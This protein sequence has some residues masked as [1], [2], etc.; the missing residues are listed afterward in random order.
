[1]T[2]LGYIIIYLLQRVFECDFMMCHQTSYDP[3][4]RCSNISFVEYV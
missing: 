4:L 1:V 3:F 2:T